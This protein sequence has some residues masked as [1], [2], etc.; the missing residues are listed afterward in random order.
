MAILCVNRELAFQTVKNLTAMPE[1]QV[2]SLGWEYPL[3]KGIPTPVFLPEEFHEHR[4][5]AVCSP[6]GH[7]E[8][9]KTEQL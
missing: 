6:W 9:D 8:S 7:K 3:E 5:L 1:T 2:R 4:S